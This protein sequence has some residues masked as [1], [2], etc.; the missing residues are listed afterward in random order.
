M[1]G[2]FLERV[3]SIIKRALGKTSLLPLDLVMSAHDAWGRRSH[4][5]AMLGNSLRTKPNLKV[6]QRRGLLTLNLF[7]LNSTDR[8]KAA[9]TIIEF[10]NYDLGSPL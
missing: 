6:A 10:L 8:I 7:C 1:L 2:S 4:F 9:F 3:S 5:E